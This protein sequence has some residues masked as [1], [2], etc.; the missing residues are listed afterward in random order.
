MYIF[1][2]NKYKY[3]L[4]IKL[5]QRETG[6]RCGLILYLDLFYSISQEQKFEHLPHRKTN[7]ELNMNIHKSFNFFILDVSIG[8]HNGVAQNDHELI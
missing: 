7:N 6:A 8:F 3:K 2:F 4:Y 5:R 1:S